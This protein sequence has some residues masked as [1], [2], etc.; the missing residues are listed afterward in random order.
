MAAQS[1]EFDYWTDSTGAGSQ[2][3]DAAIPEA[4]VVE[5]IE[6]IE[7]LSLQLGTTEPDTTPAP[8]RNALFGQPEPTP[9]EIAAGAGKDL[10]P[11]ETFAILDAA[12]LPGLPETLATSG[13]EHACLFQGKAEEELSEVAPWIVTLKEQHSFTRSLFSR[14]DAP[15]HWWDKDPAIF[16]R[17]RAG[18]DAVRRHLRK[19]TKLRDEDGK[20]FYVRFWEA[21]VLAALHEGGADTQSFL[22][23]LVAPIREW[24]Q[25]WVAIEQ[26][27]GRALSVQGP[28]KSAPKPA[29]LQLDRAVYD[30]LGDAARHRL[31]RGEAQAALA[32]FRAGGLEQQIDPATLK[33]LWGQLR[34]AGFAT[35]KHR[36]DAMVLYLRSAT[37]NRQNEAWSV[38]STPG[39]GPAIRVWRLAQAL[40]GHA[41]DA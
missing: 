9:A 41:E 10:P 28:Q 4:P 12:R 27:A 7:P 33:D 24:P 3:R 16:L 29:P 36:T 31:F 20:W 30:A 13:L 35:P 38:L 25:R 1:D 23:Q 26:D 18:L 22:S 19:F 11:L 6:P 14:S 32:E 39:P 15:Q 34:Q 5:I 40:E 37:M 17:T 2:V 8:L 21:K